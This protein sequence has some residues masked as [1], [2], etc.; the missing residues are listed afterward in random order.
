MN[1]ICKINHGKDIKY[2]FFNFIVTYVL[3]Y[4]IDSLLKIY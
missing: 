3:L 1:F 4:A 2:A